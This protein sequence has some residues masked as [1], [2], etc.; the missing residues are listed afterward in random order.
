MVIWCEVGKDSGFVP[1]YCV[2]KNRRNGEAERDPG[3]LHLIKLEHLYS[4]LYS[5]SIFY[6]DIMDFCT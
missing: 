4:Y 1:M 6:V 3:S 5:S 2:P